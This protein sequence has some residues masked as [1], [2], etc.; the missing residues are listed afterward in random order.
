MK[1][2]TLVLI[3]LIYLGAINVYA[4]EP[5]VSKG[6]L[7]I[8]ATKD[9]QDALRVAKEAS[10]KLE[11]EINLR[12]YYADKITGLKTDE[13]CECGELHDYVARGRYDDGN[14]ISIEYSDQYQEFAKGLYIV[15]TSSGS[16]EELAGAL[17]KAKEFY[18]DA[19]IKNASVY[20][21]CMH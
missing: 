8:Y 12:G 2:L 1:K 6:F 19:Y 21:G 3:F 16:T 17:S 10:S 7:I 5:I 9:Y 14:Y 20:I 15:I 18:I 13:E 4:Q 11:L